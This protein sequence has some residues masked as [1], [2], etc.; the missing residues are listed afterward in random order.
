MNNKFE[1]PLLFDIPAYDG[2]GEMR[3]WMKLQFVFDPLWC[4]TAKQMLIIADKFKVRG[5]KPLEIYEEIIDE[6]T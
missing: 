2:V 4:P 3:K 1:Q 6:K 5:R